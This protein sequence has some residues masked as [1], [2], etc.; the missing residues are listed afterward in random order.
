MKNFRLLITVSILTFVLALS[1]TNVNAQEISV[2]TDIVSKYMWR[3]LEFNDAPN[4]QPS[5]SYSN[6]GF[7][8]GFWG[9]YSITDNGSGNYEEIDAYIG[10]T[11]TVGET[12][13][14]VTLTDYYLPTA[15]A[16]GHFDQDGVHTYEISVSVSTGHFSST[17]ANNIFNDPGRN[18]YYEV[19]Y[20][21]SVGN[22][23]LNLFVGATNGS[24]KNPDYYGSKDFAIINVGITGSKSIKVTDDFEIPV[25]TTFMFNPKVDAGYLVFGL[26]L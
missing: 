1:Y 24:T 9:S 15:G 10:Y 4:F 26:S 13:I 14:G 18:T 6:S 22:V 25:F 3:G 11:Y 2:G 16:L 19:G 7:D 23:D 12:D 21:T 5:L 20:S 17:I 8:I